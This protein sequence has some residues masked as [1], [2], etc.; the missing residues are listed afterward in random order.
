[1]KTAADPLEPQ[2]RTA[3]GSNQLAQCLVL[4]LRCSAT[5]T[6]MGVRRTKG[7]LLGCRESMIHPCHGV[8]SLDTAP[9]SIFLAL[10]LALCLS[11]NSKFHTL[12]QMQSHQPQPFLNA[13]PP[14]S[15][16]AWGLTCPLV[17]SQ[18]RWIWFQF[19]RHHLQHFHKT[20]SQE[21]TGI[22]SSCLAIDSFYQ[23]HS[24]LHC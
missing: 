14:S 23:C 13:L 8:S 20:P 11:L 7:C 2:A 4:L 16:H 24:H 6:A 19:T 1:M 12:N 10:H 3:A 9:F 15:S 5:R 22:L 21:W 17:S 18:C